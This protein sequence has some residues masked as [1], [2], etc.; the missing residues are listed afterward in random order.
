MHD[1]VAL[2]GQVRRRIRALV[3]DQPA[4][5]LA[6]VVP[7]LGLD[8]SDVVGHLA[9]MAVEPTQARVCDPQ[10]ASRQAAARRGRPLSEVLDEWDAAGEHLAANHPEL[11]LVDAVTHE[12]DIRTALDLPGFRDDA[13]VLA[14]LDTMAEALSKRVAARGLPAI[15]ITVEQW[16]TI[17]GEGPAMRCLVADR[18]DFVR[19]MAG[20]RS[21]RQIEK[22]NWD[23]TAGDYLEVL[24]AGG[25]L[26]TE[27]VRE[28]DPRVPQHMQDFDLR[29]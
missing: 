6:Q 20:R 12:H 27:D 28:R 2:L 5:A 29:H 3:E 25:T 17:A 8:V 1:S 19:G 18:F 9:G 10:A 24:P 4:S 13:S 26:P 21:A 15:R 14:V 11:L 22:W 7:V 16:G 23:S